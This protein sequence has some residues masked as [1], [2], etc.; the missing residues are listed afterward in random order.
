MS[1]LFPFLL[2][3]LLAACATQAPAP[4]SDRSTGGAAAPAAP[5]AE[6]RP[7]HYLVKKGDTL[8]RIALD[9]GLD[10]KDV[11]AWNNLDNPNRIE[12]GQQLRVVPPEGSAVAVV[13]PVTTSAPV[14]VKPIAPAT[15]PATVAPAPASASTATLKRDPKGGKLP[16]SEENLASLRAAEGGPLPTAAVAPAP[17]AKPVDKP[18][19]AASEDGIDW[20]W[21]ASGSLLVGFVEGGAAPN[22][23]LDIAGKTGEPVLA[24]AAGKIVY[25]GSGLRGYGNLVIVRHSAAFLS[26]YA[27]NSKILVKE[28]AAV[29]KGQKIAE[30]GSSDTDQAKLHFE[31]RRQGKPVDP[32]KY[33][34]TR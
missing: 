2:V 28:G 13:K 8:H 17:D 31:I 22:K 16:Y 14:E 30:I 9:H 1:R 6:A 34:P 33:L 24:A 10:Y 25:V 20:A 12:V 32:A 29:T 11:V 26:A 7:G 27:H 19:T 15:P 5:A 21:P 3:T 4:V 23:G 18:A